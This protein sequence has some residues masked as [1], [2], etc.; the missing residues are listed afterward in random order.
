MG[1]SIM[2]HV[3]GV[4]LGGSKILAGVFDASLRLCGTAKVTT[5]TYR[6]T[7]SIMDRIVRAVEYAVDEADLAL[8]QVAAVAVGVP[9]VIDSDLGLVKRS[10]NLNW[11]DLH[12]KA[13]L[14]EKLQRP[15]FVQNDCS[16]AMRAIY[17]KEL[18]SKPKDVVG[19]FI[20]SGIGVAAVREYHLVTDPAHPLF[21]FAHQPTASAGSSCDC[22][23]QGCLHSVVGRNG[24]AFQLKQAIAGGAKTS[25]DD[26]ILDDT[27][28]LKSG[29]LRKAIRRGDLVV[30]EA[31]ESAASHL[32][33]AIG[34]LMDSAK[35]DVVILGGGIIEALGDTMMPI[36]R[37]TASETMATSPCDTTR[38]VESKLA[39]Q[40]AI[41]GAAMLAFESLPQ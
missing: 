6:G 35:P 15:V 20:G 5:K 4:D 9:G 18:E 32:G 33:V 1:D 25:L 36:I 14:E 37:K 30:K 22:G 11:Q 2:N 28:K 31:V 13:V 24:I 7:L 41:I 16:M 8:E 3:V 21:Q 17:T 23:C 40:A 19:I 10:W 39:D 26:L 12:L 38:I 34:R 29:H 27:G